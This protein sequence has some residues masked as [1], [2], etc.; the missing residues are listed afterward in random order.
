MQVTVTE[1][2][3]RQ[4]AEYAKQMGKEGYGLKIS[5]YPGGCAGFQYGLDLVKEPS[6]EDDI[7]HANGVKVFVEREMDALL[8]GMTIDFVQTLMGGGF[9][10]NNPNAKSSCGCGH[11]F[12]A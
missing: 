6:P 3:E 10:I 8:D 12:Q 2:A 9:Q 7:V 11:S 5:V 4:L 1:A